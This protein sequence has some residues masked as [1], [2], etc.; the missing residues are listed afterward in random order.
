MRAVV[1]LLLLSIPWSVLAADS[2]SP[3][4]ADVAY[5]EHPKQ[6]MHFWQA[7]S[8]APA[9]LLFFI[10]GGGWQAGDRMNKHLLNMLPAMLEQGVSVVS[11]EYRFIREAVA[12]GVEPPVKAPLHDAARALQ[13]VR[14][15]ADAWNIDTSRIAACGSSA[16]ACSSLWLAFHDDLADADSPDAVA[17]QSTRLRSAAVIGA[18]T[19]LDPAQM[20]EWTPNSRYGSHAFG[21]FKPT[22]KAFQQDFEAFL[23]KRSEIL[24]WIEEYSPYALVSADDPPVYLFYTA[25]PALGKPQ[26]DPTHT[27]NFG[28]KLQQRLREVGVASEL[29]YPGAPQVTHASVQD[30]LLA[31]LLP[32]TPAQQPAA[33]RRKPNPAMAKVEDLPG[34]PRVLLIGDYISIGYTVP[35]RQL[36]E[37]K[38][39]V[40]RP[41]T[42]C[43]PTTKALAELDQWLG[44]GTWDVIHFNFG[45]HDLKYMGPN[46]E[47]LA[48]PKL[49]TSHP[50]VPL[51]EYEANLRK[52]VQRL[53]QTGAT[54][55]WRT[56]TPVPAGAAGRVVG[57]AAKYNAVAKQIMEEAGIAI[58]DQYTFALQRLEQLQLPANVHFTP[59][60]SQALAEQAVAAIEQALRSK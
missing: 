4:K 48:D 16:G 51:D 42:N 29:V 12:E 52:I 30:Y 33:A 28:V 18:Q 3:T 49:P 1:C 55:I 36:L 46:Q 40:H 7:E 35:V 15:K 19:T 53:Q 17:R 57:D 25:P 22:G 41:L 11:I 39:N 9:P 13:F 5:G 56:T 34:L 54:L 37:G 23:A 32:E 8:D 44:E 43:G 50:Q 10:H 38:A 14:S 27:S 26:K 6:V 21:I 60:G 45:L 24:P 58:D 59:A 20:K 47:N 31:T 2:P